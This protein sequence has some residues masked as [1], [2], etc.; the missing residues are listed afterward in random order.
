MINALFS[1]SV[2]AIERLRAGF[3]VADNIKNTKKE[4]TMNIMRQSACLVVN[5]IAV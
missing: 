3:N 5:P 1:H 4:Y 2:Y